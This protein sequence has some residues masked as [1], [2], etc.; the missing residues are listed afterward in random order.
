[1]FLV[2]RGSATPAQLAPIAG[3]SIQG[4]NNRLRRLYDLRILDRVQIS[5]P[6]GGKQFQYRIALTADPERRATQKGQD[7]FDPRDAPQ[8]GP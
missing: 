4:A 8:E 7:P 6:G 1:M 3:C 2:E 5:V